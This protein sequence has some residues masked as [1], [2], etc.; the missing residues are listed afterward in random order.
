MLLP[1][2][3]QLGSISWKQAVSTAQGPSPPVLWQADVHTPKH[4]LMSVDYKYLT[5]A[6]C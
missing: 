6:N 5:S 1:E 2:G 3:M 4:F